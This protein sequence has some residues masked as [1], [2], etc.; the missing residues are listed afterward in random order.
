MLL[1]EAYLKSFGLKSKHLR[2]PLNLQLNFFVIEL[3]ESKNI[4]CPYSIWSIGVSL[5][6]VWYLFV[7]ASSFLD[8]II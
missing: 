8:S 2:T 6:D 1:I 3:L 4:K 5:V 7:A